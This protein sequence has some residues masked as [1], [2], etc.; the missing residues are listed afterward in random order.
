[1]ILIIRFH[2]GRSI[3]HKFLWHG[4]SDRDAPTLSQLPPYNAHQNAIGEGRSISCRFRYTSQQCPFLEA[5]NSMGHR[6]SSGGTTGIQSSRVRVPWLVRASPPP[7]TSASGGRHPMRLTHKT[8]LATPRGTRLVR[9]CSVRGRERPRRRHRAR[10][11]FCLAR[12]R[13]PGAI[14]ICMGNGTAHHCVPLV[15]PSFFA[16]L[17]SSTRRA[18]RLNP[19]HT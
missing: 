6:P 13:Q 19:H 2:G 7:T 1:M 11:R 12:R 14:V 5:C 18:Q 9:T 16:S 8:Q 15:P 17:G 10:Q 3:D 4:M